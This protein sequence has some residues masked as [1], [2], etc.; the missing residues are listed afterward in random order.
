MSRWITNIEARETLERDTSEIG[1]LKLV[2][3]DRTMALIRKEHGDVVLGP[4][5]GTEERTATQ[6]AADGIIG[7][8]EPNTAFKR[9]PESVSRETV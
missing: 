5:M 3:H 8:Y 1:A 4:P 7:L 2:G 9:H 6:I